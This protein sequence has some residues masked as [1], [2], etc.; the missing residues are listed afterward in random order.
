M[1][2]YMP[3]DKQDADQIPPEVEPEEQ[4]LE[5][6]GDDDAERNQHSL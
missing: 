3:A 4:E 1:N 2:E 5:Y 6:N